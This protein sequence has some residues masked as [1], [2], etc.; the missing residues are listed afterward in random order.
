MNDYAGKMCPYCKTEILPEDDVVVCSQCEMPHHKDCWVDNQGCTTFGCQGTIKNAGS[1]TTSVTATQMQYEEASAGVYCA[2]CGAA[3]DATYS[4]CAKCGS[5][6]TAAPQPAQT[7]AQ[8]AYQQPA[9]DQTANQQQTYQQ[10]SY[11]QA[12]YQQQMQAYQQ[13]MQ[14]YQQQ[15]QAYQQQAQAYQQPTYQQQAQAYQQ[16]TYQQQ[17]QAYQQSTYQQPTYQQPTYDQN[18]Y[19]QQAY[20]QAAYQQTAYQ[21]PTYQQAAAGG[22]Y[23]AAGMDPDVVALIGTKQEYYIPKFQEMKTQNK[24][25]T[26]NWPAFLVTPYWLIYRKMYL[27][28]IIALAVNFVISLLGVPLLSVLLFAGYI[29][30]GVLGN[31]IYMNYLEGKAGEMKGMPEPQRSQFLASNSG[32]NSGA[33]VIAIVVYFVVNLLIML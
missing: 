27:Y 17:A 10:P 30:A 28:G 19:Q 12:A 1:E 26:W 18:A 15:A 21:Q 33:T 11:D 2:Q 8:P 20:Q 22:A 16:P 3:N 4:F 7:Y 6:L 13:Q 25:N 29:A 5:R 9:Y 32:V 23:Q 31:G 14:A 24:R